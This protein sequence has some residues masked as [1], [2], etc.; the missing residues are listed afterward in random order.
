MDSER[1]VLWIKV[2]FNPFSFY[3]IIKIV[4]R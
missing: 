4:L 1:N 2:Y 3:S